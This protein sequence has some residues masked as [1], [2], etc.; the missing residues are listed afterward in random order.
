MQ[1]TNQKNLPNKNLE[2][3]KKFLVDRNIWQQSILRKNASCHT[4]VQGYITTQPQGTVR[5]RTK[6]TQAF[7]TIKGKAIGITRAEFEYPIP[8]EDAQKML[9]AFTKRHIV[10]KRYVFTYKGF[11]W[12][13]DEFEGEQSPLILAEV[14]LTSEKENPICPDFITE[15]VSEDIRYTNSFLS[16]KPYPTW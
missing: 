12:E 2:I 9:S 4:I 8:Y 10:K 16:Q 5:I 1:K 15:D 11:T 3:E 7:L 6:D 13:L 14:E